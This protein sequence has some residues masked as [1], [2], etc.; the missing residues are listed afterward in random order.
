MVSR[1]T[2]LDMRRLFALL[3]KHSTP[4]DAK[5]SASTSFPRS[6]TRIY[7]RQV[8]VSHLVG[9]LFLTDCIGLTFELTTARLL[10]RVALSVNN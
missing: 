4:E 2:F 1:T 6:Y 7:K 10:A 8:T 5:P 3:I 9:R